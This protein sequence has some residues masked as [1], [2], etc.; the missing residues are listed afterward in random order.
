MRAKR[1]PVRSILYMKRYITAL[2]AFLILF[3]A[4][5]TAQT[6]TI[7][8]QKKVY[9][10]SKPMMDF[11]RT[12]TIRRPIAKAATPTLSQKI[13]A[14][15]NPVAILDINI[16]EEMGEIQWLSEA[17]YE[18]VYNANGILTVKVWMEGAGAYPDGVTKHSVVD[19]GTGERIT[20][21]NAFTDLSSLATVIKK[22][23]QKEVEAAI[24]ELKADPE[25]KDIDVPEV[26]ENTDF[27]KESFGDLSVTG[28][29]VT[30]YYDYGFPHV[31]QALEPAGEFTLAWA[32]LKPYIKPGG[33]L[34]RFVS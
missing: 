23:Q 19:T 34:A 27:T 28:T 8:P 2:L 1:A 14:A 11:K 13:T 3:C 10:R 29:G 20:I 9:K 17:D 15:I 33:L 21:A 25:N 16:K 24:K 22:A 12:F 31:I 4:S 5:L 7:T 32:E 6:V 26:F 18:V 30:F